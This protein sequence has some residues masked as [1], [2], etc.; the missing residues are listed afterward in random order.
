MSNLPSIVIPDSVTSIG[1]SAFYNCS[2]LTSFVMTSTTPP[3]LQGWNVFG[4][5]N[6][7]L[8]I[9]VP[10]ASVNTYKSEYNWSSYADKIKPISQKPV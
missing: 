3:T 7:S 8:Q 2:G 5:T 6:S 10:D 4:Y 1:D 9:Y